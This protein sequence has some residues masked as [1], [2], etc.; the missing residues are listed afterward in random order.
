[1]DPLI[2]TNL[3]ANGGKLIPTQT[4]PGGMA[5]PLLDNTYGAILLGTFFNIILCGVEFHQAYQY[6]RGYFDDTN[7][8]RF[9]VVF[10]MIVDTLGTA[11]SVHMCYWFLITNYFTP[12]LI[13]GVWSMKS[14]GIS[15]TVTALTCQCFFARRVYHFVG[16]RFRFLLWFIIVLILGELALGSISYIEIFIVPDYLVYRK[17][18][19]CGSAA[20][21]LAAVADVMLTSILILELHRSRTG[22]KRTDSAIDVLIAYA[23]TTGL[24]TTLFNVYC[25]VIALVEPDNWVYIASDNFSTKLYVTS[26]LAALNSRLPERVLGQ[27]AEGTYTNSIEVSVHYVTGSPAATN[28]RQYSGTRLVSD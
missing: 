27:R 3:T 24:L 11:L 18:A 8:M 28:D 19:W 9:F 17:Y 2:S 5:L 16:K 12:R 10:V 22:F 26:V 23:V 14:L 20:Y 21:A 7:L 4:F 25:A 15:D 1:M 6:A 13:T